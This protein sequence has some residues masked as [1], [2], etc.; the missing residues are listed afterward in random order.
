MRLLHVIE[1]VG[2]AGHADWAAKACAS[3]VASAQDCEH[4]VV[5]SGSRADQAR[6]SRLGVDAE[7]ICAGAPRWPLAP[8]GV[9]AMEDDRG[10][11]DRVIVW[12]GGSR[13]RYRTRAARTHVGVGWRRGD[14][15]SMHLEELGPSSTPILRMAIDDREAVRRRI[16]AEHD[17]DEDELVVVLVGHA[18]DERAGSIFVFALGLVECARGP[19]VGLI[20]SSPGR[21][22]RAGRL[23]RPSHL[24]SRLAFSDEPE[25]VLL[26][27]ADACVVCA[28][29]W[30]RDGDIRLEEAC[31][32][33]SAVFAGAAATGCPLVLP[34]SARARRMA[35][36]YELMPEFV[37]NG[38]TSEVARGVLNGLERTRA[39]QNALNEGVINESAARFTKAILDGI[40]AH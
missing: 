32:V 5:L 7:L 8:P 21:G 11:F 40:F 35:D 16:R 6:A 34:D 39:E 30:L 28:R 33:N 19:V 38:T 12:G 14:A 31:D 13:W 22:C 25:D 1:R 37:L 36:H 29:S 26:C 23:Q 24:P 9:R 2:L 4:T 15:A 27:A 20:P 17:I 10:P 3:M 18:D